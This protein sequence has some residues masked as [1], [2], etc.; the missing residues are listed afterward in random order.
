MES[1]QTKKKVIL[2]KRKEQS[3]DFE[4]SQGEKRSW[5]LVFFR[6]SFDLS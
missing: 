2:K 5:S 6:Q 3:F 1:E 4:F